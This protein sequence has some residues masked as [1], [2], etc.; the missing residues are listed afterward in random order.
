LDEYDGHGD[1]GLFLGAQ[2][3]KKSNNTKKPEQS[4]NNLHK[5][6]FTHLPYGPD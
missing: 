5:Q 3:R 1:A 6:L 2:R 4:S